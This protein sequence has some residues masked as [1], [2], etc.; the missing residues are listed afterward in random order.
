MVDEQRFLSRDQ[1][2][3]RSPKAAKDLATVQAHIAARKS[4]A[5]LGD[6]PP[7]NAEAVRRALAFY[8]E[9]IRNGTAPA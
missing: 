3:I 1:V 8:A 2:T 7:G 6:A 4:A 9:A 5:G